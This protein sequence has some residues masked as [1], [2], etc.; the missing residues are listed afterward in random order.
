MPDRVIRDELLTSER[1]WRCSPEA[2]NLYI[3][4]LLSVDDAARMSGAPFV[5]RMR[6]MA[7]TV[8]HE[9]IEAILSELIDCDLVRRYEV[10]NKTYLFVPRFRNRKRYAASS[11]CPEPPKEINDIVEKKTDSGHTK[12]NPKTDSSQTQDERSGEERRGEGLERSGVS[13]T[14]GVSNTPPSREETP[15]TPDRNKIHKSKTQSKTKTLESNGWH[16]TNEGIEAKARELGI[17]PNPGEAYPEFKDRLFAAIA[18]R[19][20]VA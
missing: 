6:C 13:L 4:I 8:S 7:G 12:D 2:R 16:K 11:K 3:S 5:L 10:I 20:R 17:Q 19:M 9:R 18:A 1:Y 15:S 14:P